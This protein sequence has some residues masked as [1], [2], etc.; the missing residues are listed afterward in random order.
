MGIN[1]SATCV[2]NFDGARGFMV[3]EPNK[4]LRAMFTMMNVARIGTGMQ[5]MSAGE[6]SRQGALEYAKDRLQM[7]SLTG[8]KEPDKPADPIIVHPDVRRMLL[9]QKAFAEGSRAMAYYCGML[10]DLDRRKAGTDE[11][12]DALEKMELLTPICKGFMTDTGSES[13][14]LGVQVFGGHGYIRE[15]GMEQLI[16]DARVLQLYEGANG[17]QALD[18][19]GRKV[20]ATGG[21]RLKK[22]TDEIDAFCAEQKTEEMKP[23]VEALNA[24][25]KEWNELTGKI[26]EKAMKNPDEAG[27]ASYDFLSYSG[28]VCYA[29]FFARMASVSLKALAEGTD[30]ED[31]Y[32]AKL[33]TAKFYFK[34]LLPRTRALVETMMGDA[35]ELMALDAELF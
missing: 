31:F 20:L 23:Y 30:E 22:F 14:N 7:R 27:A 32:K 11:A 13:A 26:L 19:L 8:P 2:L 9:T 29:Y 17:I 35:E 33:L 25:T 3:G 12:A 28:Y 5:G 15:H 18:L 1:S 16:R 21:A 10:A 34:R 6:M 24:H 4:G